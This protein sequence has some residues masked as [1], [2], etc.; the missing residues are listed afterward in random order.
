M[1]DINS[2]PVL[3]AGDLVTVFETGVDTILTDF[4]FPSIQETVFVF[5]E[6][7]ARLTVIASGQTY[8]VKPNQSIRITEDTATLQVKSDFGSQ[9]FRIT[10]R[11]S[12]DNKVKSTNIKEI[13]ENVN[14]FEYSPDGSTWKQVQ[15]GA[16]ASAISTSPLDYS[17]DKTG[18]N[19]SL[20]AFNSALATGK[21]VFVP[22][23][24][25]K[26]TGTIVVPRKATLIMSANAV[27]KPSGNFNVIQLKPECRVIGGKIDTSGVASFTSACLYAT[28]QDTFQPYQQLTIVKDMNFLGKEHE[29]DASPTSTSWT[30]KGIHFYSGNSSNTA[31]GNGAY[32]AY[33]QVSNIN[34]TNF[35]RGIYLE[36][37]KTPI[38]G[39]PW[40]TSC[41]FDQIGMMNC[42]RSIDITTN[43][44]FY[45]GGHLFTNL[46]LQ[47]NSYCERYVYAD[48]SNNIFQ[49]EFW[50]IESYFEPRGVPC[51]EFTATA[52]ENF[53]D[54]TQYYAPDKHYIDKNNTPMK[55]NRFRS[56]TNSVNILPPVVTNSIRNLIGDQDDILAGASKAFT[57][58]KTSAHTSGGGSLDNMFT[59]TKG[60]YYS[61]DGVDEA[62]NCI[63]E[64][65]CTSN[66]ISEIDMLGFIFRSDTNNYVPKYI[67]MDLLDSGGAVLATKSITNNTQ[68]FVYFSTYASSTYKIR[69]T[70]GSS[71][72]GTASR[73]I[74]IYRIF[75]TA[76]G[77]S[78][79]AW[80]NTAE[81]GTL[82]GILNM[83][84][85]KTTN[86]VLDSG[87]TA[88]RPTNPVI[89][90]VFYDTTL[91]K[92][93][94]CKVGGGTPTW[95][96]SA[97]TAV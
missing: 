78:G 27:I 6:G 83:N 64:I 65:N 93:I 74:R 7:T 53:V 29:S 36:R 3:D 76:I 47:A 9:P 57:V 4:V 48:G 95:T 62:N 55:P 97:G 24:I 38:N 58:T 85:N 14:V 25:Y 49:G 17:A 87:A 28:G 67:K 31:F 41:T 13:R 50:D 59:P 84:K 30:G 56:I 20:A 75:A 16:G 12:G 71:N 15:G 60:T 10:G 44:S 66:P 18:V 42:M 40:I 21:Y 52:H 37:E 86:F 92:P 63:I 39:N 23:G 88:S 79:K 51:F 35:Y 91:G 11:T 68:G 73:R 46:Q 94:F 43:D 32:I 26:V 5:N 89:G 80:L 90:Q 33:I 69:L 8:H 19:D 2:T 70:F 22:D 34:I 61:L 81:G 82:Y 96:D 72:D 77:S 1:V 54:G 45:N